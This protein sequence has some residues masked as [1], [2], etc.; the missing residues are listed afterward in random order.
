MVFFFLFGASSWLALAVARCLNSLFGKR[1]ISL[2]ATLSQIVQTRLWGVHPIQNLIRPPTTPLSALESFPTVPDGAES[3]I[4]NFARDFD[5]RLQLPGASFQ[6]FL[7]AN[8][9]C[10]VLG[11][12]VRDGG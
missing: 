9:S 8:N 11:R 12:V 5:P 3:Q 6:H 7:A 10:E 4:P 2:G 1:S